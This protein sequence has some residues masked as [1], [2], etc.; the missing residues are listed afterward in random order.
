MEKSI[1]DILVEKA[2]TAQ[3]KIADYTQ[4]QIDD[5][6]KSIAW[7]VYKDENIRQLAKLAVEETGMGN[8]GGV[9]ACLLSRLGAKIIA[10]S[11]SSCGVYDEG[12]LDVEV[13]FDYLS[14]GRKNTLEVYAKDNNLQIKENLYNLRHAK[15]LLF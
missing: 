11:D 1:I 4:E 7:Q 8:V 10:V 2:R 12:G 13:I 3:E 5:V 9:A 6:C 14:G 15:H